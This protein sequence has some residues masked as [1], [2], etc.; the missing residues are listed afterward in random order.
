MITFSILNNCKFIQQINVTSP[1]VLI[2]NC[3]NFCNKQKIKYNLKIMPHTSNKF[4]TPN[5]KTLNIIH[6]AL[7]FVNQ[8]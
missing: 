4:Q 7:N 6:I 2:L 5:L 8:Y 1:N 3:E